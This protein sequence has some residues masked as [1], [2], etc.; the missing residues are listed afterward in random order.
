MAESLG[1]LRSPAHFCPDGEA[2]SVSIRW[3][4]WK[5]EFGLYADCKGMFND[6]PTPDTTRAE[7]CRRKRRALFLY[8]LGPK[9]REIFNGLDRKST[10][11]NSSH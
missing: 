11:L 2:S 10:R 4:A 1:D 8:C 6:K 9:V 5:D 3:K 7:T